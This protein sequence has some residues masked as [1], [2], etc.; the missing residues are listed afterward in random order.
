MYI[1]CQL[2]YAIIDWTDHIHCTSQ[3][4]GC[5]AACQCKNL[6]K[7]FKIVIVTP[8][9]SEKLITVIKIGEFSIKTRKYSL[10]ILFVKAN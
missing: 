6:I 4:C 1:S 10:N 8:F 5:L 3:I 9:K 2:Y 7:G